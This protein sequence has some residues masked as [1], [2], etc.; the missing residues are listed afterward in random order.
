M[1]VCDI[2]RINMIQPYNRILTIGADGYNRLEGGEH[3]FEPA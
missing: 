2:R 3:H 1:Y